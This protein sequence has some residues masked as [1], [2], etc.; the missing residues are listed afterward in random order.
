[1]NRTRWVFVMGLC[2]IVIAGLMFWPSG[3]KEPS[4]DGRS[5]SSWLDA[6][7]ESSNNRT[8]HATIA[9]RA[10][11]SNGVPILLAR[12]SDE[13]SPDTRK[14]WRI[15]TKVVP[16]D[17][18]PIDGRITGVV[19]AAEAIN[20]LGTEAKSAFPTLTNLLSKRTHCLPAAIALAGI[21]YEGVAVL[22]QALTNQDWGVRH[23]AAFA[24]EE[25]GSDLDKVVPAL[26]EVAKIGGSNELDCLLRG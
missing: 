21:G 11:G 10:I 4:F 24:L 7:S 1:M 22:M 15:A 2:G 6:W 26:I 8:N 14:F 3:P 13:E 5:L 19:T 18:D 20:L 16:R 25:A 9:I 23:S 17:W 12:L